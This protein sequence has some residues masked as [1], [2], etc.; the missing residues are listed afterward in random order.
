MSGET[1]R[2]RSTPPVLISATWVA[3]SGTA[4]TRIGSSPNRSTRTP[5]PPS[6]TTQVP[7]RLSTSSADQPVFWVISD[8]SYSAYEV[9]AIDWD[10]YNNVFWSDEEGHVYWNRFDGQSWDG[11]KQLLHDRIRRL[12]L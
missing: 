7:T 12:P 9:Y 8:D 4:A 1:S 3:I 10:G 11:V 5:S 6:V 2:I